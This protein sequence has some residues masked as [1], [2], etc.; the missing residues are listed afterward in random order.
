M[1]FPRPPWLTDEDDRRVTE[2]MFTQGIIDIVPRKG[3]SVPPVEPPDPADVTTN[4]TLAPLVQGLKSGNAAERIR[5]ANELGKLGAAAKPAVRALC[6]VAAYDFGELRQAAVD[7]LERIEPALA[8]PVATL[9]ADESSRNCAVAA[10]QMAKMGGSASPAVPVL[11]WHARRGK[12]FDVEADLDALATVGPR[13]PEAVRAI[14]AHARSPIS[15]GVLDAS[16]RNE[17]TAA[18]EVLGWLTQ[19]RGS[20]RQEIVGFLVKTLA[21]CEGER[22]RARVIRSPLVAAIGSLEGYG[23]DAKEAIPVLKR[24]R[25]NASKHVRAAAA[26]A[27]ERIDR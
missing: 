22:L 2:D 26:S 8:K 9:L 21:E 15:G 10:R 6:E 11:V 23:P 24:L 18:L 20:L 19:N 13:D 14:I 25:L 7:A 27:L 16:G 3:R 12:A 4:R 17:R 1:V 5:S